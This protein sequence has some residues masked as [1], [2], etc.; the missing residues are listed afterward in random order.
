M[1]KLLEK[2]ETLGQ[3]VKEQCWIPRSSEGQGHNVTYWWKGLDLSN[4]VLEYEVNRLTNENVIGGKK[5]FYRK[6]RQ[7]RFHQ[8]LRLSSFLHILR[9][10]TATV[11]SVPVHLFRSCAYKKYGWNDMLISIHSPHTIWLGWV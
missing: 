4:N 2:N 9:L 11:L 8:S 7:P 3:I 1:K 10:Y 5:N 6:R